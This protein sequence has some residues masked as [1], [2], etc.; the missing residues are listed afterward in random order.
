MLL[1]G[2][3]L[4]FAAILLLMRKKSQGA[5]TLAVITYNYLFAVVM[6]TATVLANTDYS[7]Q[8]T[9]ETILKSIYSSP[10]AITFRGNMG[11]ASGIQQIAIYCI[12]SIYTLRAAVTLFFRKAANLLRMGWRV[13]R[14][15]EIYVLW[16]G[17]EDAGVLAKDIASRVRRPAV[18]WIP[19]SGNADSGMAVLP[20]DETF[21][22]RLKARRTYHVTL[23]P[24]PDGRNPARLRKLDAI[25]RKGTPLRVTAVLDDDTLRLDTVKYERID[26]YLVSEGALLF[27]KA[28]EAG[29]PLELTEKRAGGTVREGV[30]VPA[31]PFR[32]ASAG[33]GPLTRA[34]LLSACENAAFETGDSPCGLEATVYGAD[35]KAWRGF[36]MDYPAL[37]LSAELRQGT[38]DA[39]FALAEA[40][41]AP[42]TRPDCILIAAESTA[43]NAVLAKRLLRGMNRIGLAEEKRPLLLVAVRESADSGVAMLEG[44]PEVFLLRQDRTILN[45]DA[46]ILRAGDR[47]AEEFHRQ[48]REKNPQSPV[49]SALDT[50]TQDSNRAAVRDEE[51]KRLLARD[52]TEEGETALWALARYEHRR[53]VAFHAAHGWVPLAPEELTEEERAG[54]I[55]KR[56]EER[57]H[58]CM[59]GWDELNALP[60]REPGLLQRYDYENVK[61]VFEDTG[62]SGR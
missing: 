34:F 6:Q 5:R 31:R 26:A 25:P 54:F 32:L 13:A 45:Y 37:S 30:F 62:K 46:L 38:G 43:E 53:W 28:L 52:L 20:S 3:I 4:G 42:E 58:A 10:P 56:T 23:L 47:K 40:L 8:T 35:A 57:R 22:D 41:G 60:Q 33:F 48:Y 16:G 36:L 18:V 59:T 9:A 2:Y 24:D 55:T 39:A 12:M 50:F 21:F 11:S 51:N 14:K 44:H 49:W 1:L 15:R 19:F 27:D 17:R 7:I 61:A 29:R